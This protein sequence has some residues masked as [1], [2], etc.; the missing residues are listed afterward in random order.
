[1]RLLALLLAF[2]LPV[3]A[4]LVTADIDSYLRGYQAANRIPGLAWAVVSRDGV[5][6]QGAW[7]T[8]TQT[9]FLIGSVSKPFTATAVLRLAETGRI[10]LD[11]PVRAHLPWFRLA[12]E[13]AAARI[14]VRQLLTHT[15]GLAQWASRTDRFDN[16][17]DGLARS[18][19]D[20]SSVRP[21]HPPGAA[22][23]YSDANYMVLGAMVEQVT[24]QPF[25]TYLHRAVLDPLGMRRVVTTPA[26]ASALPPGHRYW[27]G[28]P[29]PFDAGYDTSGL[30]YGYLGADLESM[31]RFASAML[32]DCPGCT[33]WADIGGGSRYGFGWRESRVDGVRAVWHAGATPGFFAHVVLAPEA[34]I[35]VVLLA[36]VYSPLRD[37]ALAAAAFDVLRLIRGGAPQPVGGAALLDATPY[38]LAVVVVLLGVLLLRSRRK[39]RT[40][41]TVCWALTGL[42]LAGAAAALPPVLGGDLGQALLWTPDLGWPISAVITL[43]GLVALVH[44][45]G[46]ARI[47]LRGVRDARSSGDAR[48][49]PG[50]EPSLRP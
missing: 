31:T 33:G 34:G 10:H 4:P 19:R 47:R 45:G 49:R 26:E 1:M 20:L 37:P 2:L 43:G 7:G 3:P 46:L 40:A 9:P 35:G 6:R 8:T 48:R 24:G 11:D 17:R 39:R 42:A 21:E 15:S 36:D 30:P 28:H 38:A 22:H 32:T 12:D 18:V 14:T 27:F 44:L 16:S 23:E 13:A 29:R 50:V 41:T 25:S 5:L